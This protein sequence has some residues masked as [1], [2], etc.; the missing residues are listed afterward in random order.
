MTIVLHA[1]R[2]HGGAPHLSTLWFPPTFT[3]TKYTHP[4]VY[5]LPSVFFFAA[6]L[7]AAEQTQPDGDLS[8]PDFLQQRLDKS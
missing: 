1:R 2:R 6:A 8:Q 3:Y 4:I 5:H 7:V